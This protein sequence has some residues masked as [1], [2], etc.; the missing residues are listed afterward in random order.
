VNNIETTLNLAW[1]FLCAGALVR[2]W[3]LERQ[4][5]RSRSRRVR[6]LRTISVFLAAL[7]LFPCISIS[8]DYARAHLQNLNSVP[9]SDAALRDG[10]GTSLL[11]AAQL[12]ETEH[13]WP[14]APSI[15][16][17]VFWGLLVIPPEASGTRHPFHW[18]T[19]GRAPPAPLTL[20]D[21]HVQL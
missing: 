8:D 3:W 14:M 9:S 17:L 5:A 6:L 15:L 21:C 16:M 7:L 1:A 19:L 10:N 13:I 18:D 4:R 2:H 11:L 12:E 20:R